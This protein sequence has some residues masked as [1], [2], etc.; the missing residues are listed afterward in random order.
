MSKRTGYIKNTKIQ[1][2]K[3]HKSCGRRKK[4]HKLLTQLMKK[5]LKINQFIHKSKGLDGRFSPRMK[6]RFIIITLSLIGE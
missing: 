4:R 6:K 5:F 3:N 2:K 1:K